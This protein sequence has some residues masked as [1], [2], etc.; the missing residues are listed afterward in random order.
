M[1]QRRQ[2][3]NWGERIAKKYLENKGYQFLEANYSQKMG[4]IDLVFFDHSRQ[5]V[6]FVEVKT[7]QKEQYIMG[8]DSVGRSKIRKMQTVAR[9]FLLERHY[10]RFF[11]RF[12]VVSVCINGQKAEI[13]HLISV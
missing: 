8:D 2:F 10:E 13:R 11:A 4:E 1:D 3:G 7:R 5:E 12:D 9:I 6:V